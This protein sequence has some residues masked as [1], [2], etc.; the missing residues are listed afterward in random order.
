MCTLVKSGHDLVNCTLHIYTVLLH[1][2]IS[3]QILK[4][5]ITAHTYCL[6]NAVQVDRVPA[7]SWLLAMCTLDGVHMGSVLHSWDCRRSH[8]W[9]QISDTHCLPHTQYH[10]RGLVV[11]GIQCKL[12]DPFSIVG[13]FYT[14]I[15]PWISHRAFCVRILVVLFHYRTALVF[16]KAFKWQQTVCALQ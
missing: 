14:L 4:R 6:H 12:I 16:S 9:A 15:V 2:V 1:S 11:N 8:Q 5:K 13:C 7:H 10:Y 3:F